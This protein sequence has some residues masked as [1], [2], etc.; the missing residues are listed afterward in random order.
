M[1]CGEDL[2]FHPEGDGSPGGLWAER[3][4]VKE[5]TVAVKGLEGSPG[6]AG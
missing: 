2:G 6:E 4:H 3:C 1:G 5:S